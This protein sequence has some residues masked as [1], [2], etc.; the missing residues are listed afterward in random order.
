M[1]ANQ[2]LYFFSILNNNYK[3]NKNRGGLIVTTKESHRD[4]T[5]SNKGKNVVINLDNEAK[6]KNPLCPKPKVRL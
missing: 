4:G 2:D 3:D 5:M 6:K 1:L